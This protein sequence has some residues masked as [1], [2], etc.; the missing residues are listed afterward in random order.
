MSI[1][2][3]TAGK[4]LARYRAEGESGLFDRSCRPTRCP[5][6]LCSAKRREIIALCC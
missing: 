4:W 1:S 6:Q 3:L 5:H 2:A